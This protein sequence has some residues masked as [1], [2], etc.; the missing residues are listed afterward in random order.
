MTRSLNTLG[1]VSLSLIVATGILFFFLREGPPKLVI[2]EIMADNISCCP[3]VSSGSEEHDDWIEIYNAGTT[4]VNIGG[5][6]LSQDKARP[7]DHKIDDSHPELTTIPPGGFLIL[8]ADGTPEQGPLHLEFKLDQDGE[9]IGL[10]DQHA[11]TIDSY[12]FSE[13]PH[14]ISLGRTVDGGGVW[15]QFSK[16]T[17]GRGNGGG[18]Q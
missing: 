4:P 5:M 1:L 18:N 7:T 6:Y 8:W 9:Y 2:N 14:D 17:P 15:T 11:R 16:P 12:A 3:D 10:F 13:Q